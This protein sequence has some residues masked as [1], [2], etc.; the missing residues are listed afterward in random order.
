M[1]AASAKPLIVT[2]RQ[3][4]KKKKKKT[5]TLGGAATWLRKQTASNAP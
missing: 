3:K 5:K 2:L 1:A 4:L